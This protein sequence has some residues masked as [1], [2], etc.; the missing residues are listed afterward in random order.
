MNL[1]LDTHTW[2]WWL[3]KG[4]QKHFSPRVSQAIS[5][6]E[7]L[8]LSAATY[9]EISIKV[10]LGKL[11]WGNEPWNWQVLEHGLQLNQAIWLPIQR[12][13]CERAS[14]LSLH[15]RDP[16]D[17]MLIAQALV[18]DLVLVTK[19]KNIKRYGVKVLW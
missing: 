1:L 5:E 17:R 2:L 11:R 15:H 16:F 9:W 14:K 19:D 4:E 18:E 6:A 8:Y 3:V 12:A 10:S 7:S 13:H